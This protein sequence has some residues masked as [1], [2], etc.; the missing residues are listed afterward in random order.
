M[1]V[2]RDTEYWECIIDS[3]TSHI[4]LH[5]MNSPVDLAMDHNFPAGQLLHRNTDHLATVH[6]TLVQKVN[7][8]VLAGKMSFIARPI[9]EQLAPIR[10][11]PATRSRT[12]E[13]S[14]SA[15]SPI[16]FAKVV[17]CKRFT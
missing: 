17:S 7:A 6:H 13:R 4:L 12:K 1:A 8:S 9:R 14:T 2:V 11:T 10:S 5:N 3:A 15:K 16:R